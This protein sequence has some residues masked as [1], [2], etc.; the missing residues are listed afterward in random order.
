MLTSSNDFGVLKSLIQANMLS[1][2]DF[3]SNKFNDQLSKIG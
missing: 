1:G 2:I 3:P